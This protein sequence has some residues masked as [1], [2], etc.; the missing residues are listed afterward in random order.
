MDTAALYGL[1]HCE[2][3]VARAFGGRSPRPY[4]FTK[5]ERVG[6]APDKVDASLK[7]E[8]VRRE[9]EAS[10]RRLRTDCVR[11]RYRRRLGGTRAFE[12]RR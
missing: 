11:S 2:E 12:G 10:L 6:A 9:C 7:A 1:G 3:M 4:V 5:C 8:S